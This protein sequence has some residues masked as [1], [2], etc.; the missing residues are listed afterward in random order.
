MNFQENKYI[1][2][3]FFYIITGLEIYYFVTN[4]ST[5]IDLQYRHNRL[6]CIHIHFAGL[7]NNGI[8]LRYTV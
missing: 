8:T 1:D 4:F 5:A 3:A 7:D 6:F 2:E